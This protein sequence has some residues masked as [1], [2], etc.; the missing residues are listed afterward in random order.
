[1]YPAP[2]P[3]AR[4]ARAA[5]IPRVALAPAGA[6]PE[7][8]SENGSVRI[9]LLAS[10]VQPRIFGHG[11]PAG[12][13]FLVVRTRW[14]NVH[15]KARVEKAQMEGKADR[16]MGLGNFASGGGASGST[17]YVEADVAYKV[18][19]FADHVYLVADGVATALHPA[20]E[21]IPGGARLQLPFTLA[22]QGETREAHFAFLAPTGAK[23]VAL[24][25]FDYDNGH[26]LL[27]IRGSAERAAGDGSP[28]GKVLDQ[29]E[30]AALALAVH[31]LDFRREYRG[32]PAPEGWRHAVVRLGGRSRSERGGVRDIVQIDPVKFLW[33][34]ADGGYV[35]PAVGG[36]TTAEGVIR[37]TPEIYQ[38]QEV[39]FLVPASAERFR[40]GVRAKDEVVRLAAT[41]KKPGGLPRARASY[42][43][44]AT[45]EVLLLGSERRGEHLVLDVAVR[46]LVDKGVEIDADKQLL[47]VASG[48]ETPPDMGATWSLP[49]R[50]AY[51]LVVPPG[52]TVRF[53]LAFP[54]HGAAEALRVRGF[55]GEGRLKL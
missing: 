36:S 14:R 7:A 26:V 46:S 51:P 34:E 32:S 49:H 43:D 35:Y 31:S 2:T 45:M 40:L 18:P 11:A 15:A 50:P 6:K 8:A 47:L 28:P 44:G 30:T 25:F 33:L 52:A 53:E 21:E 24:Q 48:A 17:E 55:E 10:A 3:V 13:G 41:A 39:A 38:Q 22:K 27:P 4:V 37:F 9:E 19:K 20:T 29:A 23:N 16:T 1:L 5:E 54:P 42:K 12:E